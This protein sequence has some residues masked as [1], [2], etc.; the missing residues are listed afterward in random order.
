MTESYD[1]QDLLNR[2]CYNISSL[3]DEINADQNCQ[4]LLKIFLQ[5]LLE[6]Q[7]LDP[8]EAGSNARA[9]DY[10]LRDFMIDRC[11]DNILMITHERVSSFAGNWYIV[12]TLEPNMKELESLLQGIS[13]FYLF[14]ADQNI[15]AKDT[16]E[17]ILS[18]CS[19]MSY[20]H[21]R[22]ESFHALKDNEFQEWNKRCPIS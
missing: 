6:E 8:L 14:C 17:D 16:L 9:A 7:K 19:K 5:Y 11:R 21:Q 15:I 2:D 1:K 22:I 10:F 20:Y 13:M 18:A 4:R 3:D 12:N